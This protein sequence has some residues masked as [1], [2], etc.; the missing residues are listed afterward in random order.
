[1]PAKGTA[2][3][4]Y[5]LW[6]STN[7]VAQAWCSI[8][9]IRINLSLCFGNLFCSWS[10]SK[11]FLT[12]FQ[13]Y[14]TLFNLDK[15]CIWFSEPCTLSWNIKDFFVVKP[16]RKVWIG[17]GEFLSA[18]FYVKISFFWA[19]KNRCTLVSCA[20]RAPKVESRSTK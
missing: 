1:M 8:F 5:H 11:Y 20:C 15:T 7:S 9:Y 17:C 19:G 18:L 14:I 2:M 16:F 12:F 13:I 4:R 6:W 3:V 10:H